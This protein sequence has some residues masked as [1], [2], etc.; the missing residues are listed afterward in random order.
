MPLSV[1]VIEDKTSSRELLCYLLRRAGHDVLEAKTGPDG[2][3]AARH[4]L[5][6]LTLCDMMLPGLSGVEVART[7]RGDKR[8]KNLPLVAVTMFD[9][10]AARQ[11]ALAAGFD[12]YYAKPVDIIDFVADMETLLRTIQ[13]RRALKE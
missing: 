13:E 7:L 8:T 10:E 5:P 11:E 9:D 12:H 4:E 2:V 3:A 1:L 6:D